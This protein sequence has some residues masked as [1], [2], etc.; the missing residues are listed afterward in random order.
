[1]LCIKMVSKYIKIKHDRIPVSRWVSDE[2]EAASR[3]GVGL[4]SLLTKFFHTNFNR[5]RKVNNS[6][7][8][9]DYQTI[10]VC[11]QIFFYFV[12]Y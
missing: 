4:T 10:N 12:F 8:F 7:S 11:R 5:I 1:M 9:T 2:R 6:I 3:A